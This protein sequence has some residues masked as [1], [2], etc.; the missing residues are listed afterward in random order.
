[1]L[2]VGAE[3]ILKRLETVLRMKN[4]IM[5]EMP[6]SNIDPALDGLLSKDFEVINHRCYTKIGENKV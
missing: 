4:P 1:V 6:E 5:I 2:K 3:N